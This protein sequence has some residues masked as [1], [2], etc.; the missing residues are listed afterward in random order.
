ML[1]RKDRRV[2]VAMVIVIMADDQGSV[3]VVSVVLR[4]VV[5]CCV[6]L[7]CIVLCCKAREL[8]C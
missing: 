8:K 6:V 5:L 2:G 4:C 1:K 7:C 3:V